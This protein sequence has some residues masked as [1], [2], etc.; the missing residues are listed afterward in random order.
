LPAGAASKS[1]SGLA[2]EFVEQRSNTKSYEAS[3]SDLRA[4]AA[5]TAIN[6]DNGRGKSS[7]RGYEG[8]RFHGLET[9]Y[10]QQKLECERGR[11]AEYSG[12]D[13]ISHVCN[14]AATLLSGESF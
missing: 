8:V 10:S 2:K 6:P 13:V 7:C 1:G 3:I 14:L 5:I 11:E 4:E 9:S 12:Y